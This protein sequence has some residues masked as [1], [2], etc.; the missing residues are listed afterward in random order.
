[1]TDT[2]DIESV[3]AIL[4]RHKTAIMET[5]RASGVGIGKD[6]PKAKEYVLV[7]YLESKRDEPREAVA[8]E[9]VP[10]RFKVTGRFR[11]LD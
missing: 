10:L 7:V 3:R 5:Y 1:M 11:P 6:D 8:I 4:N 9:G 2:T